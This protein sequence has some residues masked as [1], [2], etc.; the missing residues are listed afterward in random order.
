ML[1]KQIPDNRL[2]NK[3]NW[4]S[5]IFYT[6]IDYSLP[7]FS[8]VINYIKIKTKAMFTSYQRTTVKVTPYYY[9]SLRTFPSPIYWVSFTE[10]WSFNAL[11][12]YTTQIAINRQ[13]TTSTLHSYHSNA[14]SGQRIPEP[15]SRISCH[16]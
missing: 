11:I 8:L 5:T 9:D 10:L 3:N 15:K 16:A 2:C 14:L 6:I 12:L 7:P 13:P 1:Q 4:L